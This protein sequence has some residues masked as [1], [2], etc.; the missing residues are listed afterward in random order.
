MRARNVLISKIG[1]N[2]SVLKMRP[3]LAITPSEVTLLLDTLAETLE[4][5]E[6]MVRPY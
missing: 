3:P 1:R 6:T 2:D 5:A 4:A